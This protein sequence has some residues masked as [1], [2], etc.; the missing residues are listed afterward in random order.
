[1]TAQD[2]VLLIGSVVAAIGTLTQLWRTRR[3]P[4]AIDT[5]TNLTAATLQTTDKIEAKTEK[6]EQKVD[7]HLS[8][9]TDELVSTRQQVM[10]LQKLVDQLL[11]HK[12]S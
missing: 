5:N 3:L 2:I 1:M 11:A 10:N 6:I 4:S 8:R 9:I 12:Q 7:G